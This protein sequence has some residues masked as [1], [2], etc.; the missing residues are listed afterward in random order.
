M[1]HLYIFE[2]GTAAVHNDP[3]PT[4]LQQ[5]IKEVKTLTETINSHSTK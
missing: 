4:D 3:T 1:K 2:N 5:L